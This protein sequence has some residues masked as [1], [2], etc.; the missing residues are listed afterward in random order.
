MPAPAAV[1]TVTFAIVAPGEAGGV[2]LGKFHRARV[3]PQM[4]V[5]AVAEVSARFAVAVLLVLVVPMKRLFDV[6]T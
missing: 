5:P 3:N 1:L 6:L 4:P 2:K